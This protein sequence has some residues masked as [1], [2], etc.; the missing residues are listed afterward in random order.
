MVGLAAAVFLTDIYR[1]RSER[2]TAAIAMTK[3]DPARAPA[4]FRRY[5]CAG[6]HTIPGIEGADGKVGGDLSGL[7]ERVY[8]AGVL[9]NSA[10]NL[11]GWIVT[12]QAYSPKTA[13]PATGI[14]EAEARD[15]AAYLYGR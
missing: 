12:P 14:S 4:I 7:R 6:C 2:Q 3:G 5:G 8:I 9:N 1:Q 11:V 10:D 13:M 15:L